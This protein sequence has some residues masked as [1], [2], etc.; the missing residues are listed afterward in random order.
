VSCVP[1]LPARGEVVEVGERLADGDL[2]DARDGDD[3][4]G[5][6]LV[7][8]DAIELLGDEQLGDLGLL[9][10]A[11]GAAPGDGLALLDVAVH[12]A[13]QRDTPQVG[14]RVEVGDQRLE[15]RVGVVGRG[16]DALEQQV[17]QRLEGGAVGQAGTVRRSVHRR[18][19]LAGHAVD[20][21]EVELL[22]GRVEVE[23]QLLHLV[24]DLRDAGVGTVDLVDHEHDGQVGL[25]GLAEHEARLGQRP[26]GGVDEE[27]HAVDHRQAPLHLATEVGV[28]RRVDDVDLHVAVGHRGVLGED[29]D[30]LLPLQV[31]GV[32]D[33]LVDVLVGPEG[34]GLP[35]HLVDEGGLAMVDVGHDGHVAEI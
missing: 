15:R 13:A 31:H 29:R 5:P 3:L 19:A 17:E 33:A 32:H 8:G 20:D 14:R 18:L 26:L 10:G 30:A 25:E 23:E 1:S 6:D 11:V 27:Q 2:R 35:E 28:A 4:A 34:P 7:G 9:G 16:G 24:D 21:R 12:D 22:E